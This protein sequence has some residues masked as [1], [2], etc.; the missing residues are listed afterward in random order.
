MS[1]DKTKHQLTAEREALRA[2]VMQNQRLES[3]GTLASGVAHEINNP[4]NGIMS[5][6][7]LIVDK[8]PEED[9]ITARSYEKEGRSWVRTTVEDQGA[10]IPDAVRDQIFDPFF[11]TKGRT[12][13]TGL[14]LSISHGIVMDHHGEHSVEDK[15]GEYTRFHLD[16]PID[17]GWELE[18]ES[19]EVRAVAT[20]PL[21]ETEILGLADLLITGLENNVAVYPAPPVTTVDLRYA[22]N[23]VGM[24]DNKLKLLGWGGRKAP[25]ALDVP[26]QCRVL[27]AP[28]EGE[29]WIFLDW[30]A[31]VGGGKVAA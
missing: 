16:L 5:C 23:T 10:G 29:G 18:E 11:T 6:A 19:Q 12:E 2:L 4:V 9:A 28:R 1:G 17:N 8:S 15:P 27:E 20:S 25:S 21:R 30:K 24:D 13:G 31:P 14:G 22:E 26:G 7:Q 3:M